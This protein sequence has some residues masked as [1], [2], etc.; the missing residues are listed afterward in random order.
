M[1]V[2]KKKFTK[3]IYLSM[4]GGVTYVLNMVGIIL[5]KMWMGR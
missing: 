4:K 2:M 1:N 3:D 5:M